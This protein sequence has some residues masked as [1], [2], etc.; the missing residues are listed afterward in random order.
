VG[1]SI[2]WHTR[3]LV[4][5]LFNHANDE[6]RICPVARQFASNTRRFRVGVREREMVRSTPI[7]VRAVAVGDVEE[8][9]GHFGISAISL[10]KNIN[11]YCK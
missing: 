11:I 9:L 6:A 2:Y 4:S 7:S 1:N 8:I 3:D 5:V 10:P